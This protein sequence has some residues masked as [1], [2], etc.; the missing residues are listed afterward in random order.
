MGPAS[1][2]YTSYSGYGDELTLAAVWLYRATN[3]EMFL[4][5]AKMHYL[6]FGVGGT[7]WAFSWD[8]NTAAVQLLMYMVTND[9]VYKSAIQSFVNGWLPNGG[10]TYTPKGLAWR[11]EWGS[12]RYSANAAFLALVA[13]DN[14]I[15]Q[16][17]LQEFAKSQIHYMLGST[18]RSFVVGFGVNPPTQPHHA[19][20]S[21]P[22][23]PAQCNWNNFNANAPNPHILYG[24][25]VGGPDAQDNYKDVRND[26][27][28]NEV[29][30]DYNA[31]FQS[32]VAG[33]KHLE[34]TG[35]L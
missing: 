33:L 32:A 12:L 5:E 15:N 9:D 11:D 14:G 13:A 19:S 35:K 10:I 24:A 25:L 20:S 6:N 31:G 4:D 22:D 27:I 3:D 29:A 1:P 28:A 30:C 34:I 26:Y 2:F 16:Q 7:P 23:K 21:C 17:A 8:D 18:G